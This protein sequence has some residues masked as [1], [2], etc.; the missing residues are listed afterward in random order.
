MALEI[1]ITSGGTISKLDD[2]R[3]IGN[4]SKG[5]TGA[6]IAEEFLKN[7]ATVHYV[8]GKEAK[9]PF[10]SALAVDPRK[11]KDEEIERVAKA[12]DEFNR[13][14]ERLHEHPI[15]TFEDY[16]ST[17]QRLLTQ[18]SP[19]AIVLAAAIGDYGGAGKEGKISSDE[20]FLRLELPKNPKVISLVKQWNPKVF[21]V[22]FKL[23]S[24]S[25]LNNLIDVAY[26]HGIK[27]H[28][29]LTVANTLIDGDFKK[30]AT[31]LITPEKGLIP[32]SLSEVAPILVN[33]VNQRVSKQHYKTKVTQDPEYTSS[34]GAEIAQF[35]EY[36]QKLSQLN[37]FEPYF[38]G[39]NK[40]FGF[41]A[42]R[43]P[44]GGFLI[45]SRG[46]DKKS[47]PID[48]VVYI[49]KVDFNSKTVY[50]TSTGKKASLNANVAAKLFEEHPEINVILHSHV[51]PGV[52]NKTTVD[53]S[54]GT[55]ED[56]DE[57]AS[58]LR[59][60][61]RIV[62]LANHGI[63][64]LGKGLEEV[65]STLDVEPAYNNF[66]E[67]YDAIYAR[68]QESTEFV[69]LVSRV[70]N[71]HESILDLA[72]G[73]GEVS[74][75]L[76]ERG[77]KSITLADRSRGMLNVALKK[78]G[79]NIPTFETTME[80]VEVKGNYDAIVVRQAI[81]Y[82]MNYGG[83]VAGFKAMHNS[84]NQGG[85]L[86]FNAPN[87]DGTSKYGERNLEYDY[88]HFHVKVKEMNSVDGNII[89][90]TQHCVLTRHD[91]SD[92]KKIYDLNRFGLITV[93]EFTKALHESGFTDVKLL[94]KGLDDYTP[95]SKTLYCVATK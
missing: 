2:V 73:T 34:M 60:N 74:S 82:L 57:V 8:Y 37:L 33:V 67:F 85:R 32:V 93:D 31:V 54:P 89:T 12:Y 17:V 30:R 51:F 7:G 92:M 21:Q 69:D 61:N 26:Q 75:Q 94:G 70:V 84:L 35:R 36:I 71:Q 42:T 9:R 50:V 72:A 79:T 63:I 48:D 18:G 13:R 46:S 78:V 29:N 22:G 59:G 27:N 6:L 44:Q 66:P 62:E 43:V 25:S 76:S 5:T 1:I 40:Q 49:P 47:M 19:D 86:V 88:G 39:S 77:Y 28:S 64:A 68:F 15:E 56:V 55:Q 87:Y 45:T 53:Y 80:K 58:H 83:L 90:H 4:F 14:A 52:S 91:G 11:S 20:D 10:R 23:L 95:K 65:I 16:Y 3:Y 24:R 81:N 41:L 38:E